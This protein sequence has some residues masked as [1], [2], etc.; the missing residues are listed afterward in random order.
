MKKLKTSANNQHDW[1]MVYADWLLECK[2][3]GSK[4]NSVVHQ[5]QKQ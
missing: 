4:T 1:Y 2:I 3:K 5:S